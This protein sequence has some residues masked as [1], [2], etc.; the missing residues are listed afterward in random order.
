LPARLLNRLW[1]MLRANTRSGSR[2][3]IIQHYDLGNAFYAC[4]LDQGMSYSSALYRE[5]D[6]SLEAA[7]TAKQ[8]RV[9]DLLAPQPGQTVLEIGCGWGGLLAR[10][11]ARGCSATGI[12]LSD[13]QHAYAVAMLEAAGL[14]ES[15]DVRLQDYRDLD[16]AFDRIVSIEMF[17]AV[18]ESYWPLY[19]AQLRGRLK[20]G[21]V[22]VLQVITIADDRFDH[23]R[24]APD[25]IQRHVFPGGMLPSPSAMR[26][27]IARAGF[28]LDAVEYF[29]ESYARTLRAWRERFGAAWPDIAAI[30]FPPHFRRLWEYY[31]GYCEAGFRVGA[32]DVGLWRLTHEQ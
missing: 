18:G 27:Q 30:G 5:R 32:I 2:R 31:L 20:P 19:F 28:R 15:T 10:L 4:W 26:E 3:N 22:A 24:R 17:E 11:A 9:L 29:G 7:Q 1:H 13:A 23:Y 8:D 6:M 14:A 16:G 12:T 25:F 21:G